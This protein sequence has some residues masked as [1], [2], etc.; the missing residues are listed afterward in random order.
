MSL[1]SYQAKNKAG[2]TIEGVV[3]AADEQAVAELLENKKLAIVSI[4][5]KPKGFFDKFNIEVLTGVKTK[6]LVIFFRQLALMVE[7]SMPVVRSLRI[8]VRQT[9]NKY[10]KS[11]ISSIADEVDGGAKLSQAMGGHP[12]VFSEFYTNVIASGETSGRLSEVMNYLAD[13]QEK[14]YDLRAK[15]KNAM[16]YPSVIIVGLLIV[17]FVMITFVIPQLTE[18]L[19]KSGTEL[20]ILTKILIAISNF[21]NNFW[22]LVILAVL[23]LVVGVTVAIK[24]TEAGR[25]IF[26]LWSIRM[27]LIGSIFRNIY[28]VRITRNLATLFQ[29]GVPAAKALETAEKVVG[30]RV[31]E[32]VLQ[33]TVR[34]VREGSS[35]SDSL[36]ASKDIPPLVSQ[37]INVGE[38]TGKLELVLEKLT[39]FYSREIDNQVSNLTVLIEPIVIVILGVA[40][41]GFVA[42]IFLPLW[43]LSSNF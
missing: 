38:E 43:Q 5:P 10:L 31:F 9:S 24:K 23:A 2:E 40:V 21:L 29:G 20:P 30:N 41:G 11:V 12:R 3:E 7:S 13:Q 26:D 33:K 4:A 28:L 14:D 6:D 16:I 34:E 39:N 32:E 18:M 25:R 36:V 42:A 35:I 22:W 8:I 1:F 27:P 15:V 37:I 19:E 17:G